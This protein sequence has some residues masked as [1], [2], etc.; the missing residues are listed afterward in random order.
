MSNTARL[1]MRTHGISVFNL[2]YPLFLV[3]ALRLAPDGASLLFSTDE[4]SPFFLYILKEGKD[5]L[6]L[7]TSDG[8]IGL[9][10]VDWKMSDI[11][12]PCRQ[13]GCCLHIDEYTPL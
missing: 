4:E 11:F 7:I 2:H 9:W 1:S 6:I 10:F 13:D 3:F 5:K 8:D 12:L